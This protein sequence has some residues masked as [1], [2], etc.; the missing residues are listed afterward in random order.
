MTSFLTTN[1]QKLE[2]AKNISFINEF[3][4]FINAMST[5]R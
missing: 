4:W 1:E 3:D 2:N 5:I